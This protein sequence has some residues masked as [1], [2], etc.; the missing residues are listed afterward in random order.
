[1]K[2]HLAQN[3]GLLTFSSHGPGYVSV[4]GT[5]YEGSVLVCG[6]DIVTDW[7][8]NGFDGL[9]AAQFER[10]GNMGAEIVLFGS[11]DRQRFPRPELL[12]AL[13]EKGIGLEVMDTKAACR[14]YNILVA[15]GRHVACGVIV[16]PSP[17]DIR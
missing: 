10:L 9:D 11:G 6:R 4:N 8:P 1:M 14:T 16:E 12:K 13:I 3:A 7:A 5:R 15:E 17:Q 2:L